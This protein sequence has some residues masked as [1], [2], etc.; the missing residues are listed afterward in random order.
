M[1]TESEIGL[2]I[3]L[4]TAHGEALERERESLSHACFPEHTRTVSMFLR[5][6][7]VFQLHMAG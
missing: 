4:Q 2:E 3:A 5:G 1:E 6:T 7:G